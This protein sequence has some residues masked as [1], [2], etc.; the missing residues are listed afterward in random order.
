VKNPLRV[1]VALD[2]ESMKIFKRL[3]EELGLSQSEIV[4]RALKFY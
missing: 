3:K 4:R 1:T 2:E